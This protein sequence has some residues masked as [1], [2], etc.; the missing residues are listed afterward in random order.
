VTQILNV[1]AKNRWP[2]AHGALRQ[3]EF[4]IFWDIAFARIVSVGPDPRA[5]QKA[6][7]QCRVPF[8]S[9]AKV[10]MSLQREGT[11]A[12][13]FETWRV[14]HPHPVGIHFLPLAPVQT[15]NTNMSDN[16]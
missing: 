4:R 12:W 16:P 3:R 9:G 1:V 8:D 6:A 13:A 5:P 2:Q 15:N 10:V 11:N 7:V 14:F